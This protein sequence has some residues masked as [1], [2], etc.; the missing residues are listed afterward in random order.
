MRPFKIV[1]AFLR[2]AVKSF[3]LGNAVIE[4]VQNAKGVTKE[5]I[6]ESG[7]VVKGAVKEPHNWVSIITQAA[8]VGLIIWAVVSKQID[9]N[10]A[11]EWLK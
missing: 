7:E 2:G 9:I 11:V 4:G 5:V 3:P 8:F 1:G 10:Q 6:T